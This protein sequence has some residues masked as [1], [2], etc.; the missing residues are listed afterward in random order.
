MTPSP[1]ALHYV[2]SLPEFRQQRNDLMRDLRDAKLPP[3]VAEKIFKAESECRVRIA[4]RSGLKAALNAELICL[5]TPGQGVRF[6]M[7]IQP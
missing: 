5:E 4:L 6:A 7:L 1:T 2:R 3:H